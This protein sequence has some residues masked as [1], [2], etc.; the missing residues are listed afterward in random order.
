MNIIE[1]FLVY[2]DEVIGF[3]DIFFSKYNYQIFHAYIYEHLVP[4]QCR[5]LVDGITYFF[6]I[7][8]DTSTFF[9][10]CLYHTYVHLFMLLEAHILAI[11]NFLVARALTISL[12][13]LLC[14]A[15]LIFA[16]GGIPRFRFDYLTK[17]G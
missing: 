12:K 7:I 13:F 4:F 6:Y 10:L 11:S 5:P 15:V 1:F 16:R 3:L 9:I 17:L 14:I 2:L 8:T